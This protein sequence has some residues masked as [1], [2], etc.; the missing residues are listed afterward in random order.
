MEY[1]QII[2]VYNVLQSRLQ[3]AHVMIM[4]AFHINR[5]IGIKIYRIYTNFTVKN[6]SSFDKTRS[7]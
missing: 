5:W 2:V 1:V 6:R 4:E 3:G 7:Y